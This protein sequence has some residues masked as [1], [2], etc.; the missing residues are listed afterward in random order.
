MSHPPSPPRRSRTGLVIALSVGGVLLVVCAVCAGLFFWWLPSDEEIRAQAERTESLQEGDCAEWSGIE[1]FD[2][3]RR[4]QGG[5]LEPA[6]CGPYTVRVD[7]RLDGIR[8]VTECPASSQF[9]YH[10]EGGRTPLTFCLS[11]AR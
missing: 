6:A 9:G 3:R 5:S 2:G 10:H 11:L 4:I 8:P 7:R 1:D